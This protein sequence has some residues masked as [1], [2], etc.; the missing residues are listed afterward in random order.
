M[1]RV[2]FG[3]VQQGGKKLKAHTKGGLKK[4][5]GKRLKSNRGGKGKGTK[6]QKNK[7]E[8]QRK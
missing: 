3:G 4:P 8:K 6:K 7:R 5:S 2:K 1:K